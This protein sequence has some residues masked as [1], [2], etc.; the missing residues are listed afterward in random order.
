SARF[1]RAP[2][3]DHFSNAIVMTG[4]SWEA[5]GSNNWATSEPGELTYWQEGTNS[6]WWRWTAPASGR[7]EVAAEPYWG[8]VRVYQGTSVSNLILL[9]TARYFYGPAFV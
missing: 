7:Y 9:A 5:V 3:N 2:P 6:V 4:H 8:I 1:L